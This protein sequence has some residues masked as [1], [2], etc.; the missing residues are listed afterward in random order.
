MV[1][2]KA[3]VFGERDPV[4]LGRWLEEE[5]SEAGGETAT[6]WVLERDLG[7]QINGANHERR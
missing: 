7:R 2:R 5:A 1:A 3:E 6:N 4:R